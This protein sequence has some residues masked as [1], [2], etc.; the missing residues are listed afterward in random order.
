MF[1][2]I[3]AII[4]NIEMR[5]MLGVIDKLDEGLYGARR[6]ELLSICQQG[7]NDYYL[8]HKIEEYVIKD[9]RIEFHCDGVVF[10]EIGYEKNGRFYLGS[11]ID[12]DYIEVKAVNDFDIYKARYLNVREAVLDKFEIKL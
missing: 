3:R 12:G 2:L 1:G 10:V 11:G 7:C 4:D 5:G 6:R 8:G 9:D